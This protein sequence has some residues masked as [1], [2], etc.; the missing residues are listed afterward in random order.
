MVAGIRN[1]PLEDI[2]STLNIECYISSFLD[3]NYN[4]PCVTS[5]TLSLAA[6]DFTSGLHEV[7]VNGHFL[8]LVPPQGIDWEVLHYSVPQAAL[9]QGRNLVEVV[10]VRDCGFIAWG[11]LAVEPC[12]EEFVPEPGSV[13]LLGGGLMGL[14]GY[15]ALRWRSRQ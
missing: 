4:R 3:L 14:A 6:F 1:M 13:M 11:A 15:A 5:F 8:G 2:S 7:Y 10:I 12:E 9:R